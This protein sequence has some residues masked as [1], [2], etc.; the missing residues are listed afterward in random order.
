VTE[1]AGPPVL[2]LSGPRLAESLE[3]LVAGSEDRGGVE[4]YVAGLRTKAS[5]FQAAL[6][7]ERIAGLDQATFLGLCAFMA[8]VRRRVGP[9][10]AEVGMDTARRALATLLDGA[11]DTG[12]PAAVDARMAR[13]G[14]AFGHGKGY[15]WVRDL[16]AEVLHC[17]MPEHYPLMTRWVWDHAANTGVLREIWHGDGDAIA[18][19]DGYQT[20]L[21]LRQELSQFL[22]SNGIYREVPLY[23]DLLCAQVYADYLCTQGGSFLR[24]EFA[25]EQD[26][27]HYTRRMLGLD[28]VDT[29]TGRTRVKGPD[30]KALV[31]DL[32]ETRH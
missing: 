23:V 30:G 16:G 10:L 9:W 7:P 29:K 22:S 3:T 31:L 24:T 32:S 4:D 20:F 25:S 19:P 15:R 28:G 5:I 21:V 2:H 11:E 8:S 13:F 6:K 12:D 17:L 26:P 18:V 27:L 1:T 14:T